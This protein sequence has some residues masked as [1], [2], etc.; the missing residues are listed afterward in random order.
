[1][2]SCVKKTRPQTQTRDYVLFYLNGLRTE[3]RGAKVLMP[4]AEWLRY[5]RGLTGT[6]IVC[7]EGDCGACTLL[8]T[9]PFRKPKLEA[10]NS[11]IA[12]VAHMDGSHVVT[13]EG[14]KD[15]DTL[16]RAQSAMMK[17]HGSQCG[18]C[19]PGF[20]MAI[21]WMLE[22]G[23]KVDGRTAKNHLTGNLCRCTGYQ[24]IIDAAIEAGRIPR[25]DTLLD[26]YFTPAAERE[27]RDALKRPVAIQD[28]LKSFYAPT[29]LAELGKLRKKQ[30]H[31]RVIAGA[32]DLGVLY[33]KT[34][35][36]FQSVIS[37][38][39]IKEM[40][41]LKVRKDSTHAGSCV[42]LGEIRREIAGRAPSVAQAFDLFA[43]PQ[44]KNMATLVGNIANASPIADT[45]PVMLALDAILWVFSPG[46][47]SARRQPLSDFFLD[48]RKTRLKPGDV[49][50][51][52]EFRLPT[53]NESFKFYKNSQRKDLDISCV[54]AAIW[55]KR[56]ANGTVSDV[57]LAYGG[58]GPTVI[59]LKKTERFL[60]GRSAT[61]S[62][63]AEA[64]GLVQ[65]E[66]S[67]IS[68]LRGSAAYRR[69]LAGNVFRSIWN[70]IAP[71]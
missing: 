24:Q 16:D 20:V 36:E 7:A 28:E 65:S 38:H 4:F 46:A 54:N 60:K 5:E 14:L 35:I 19:T 1:M 21:A 52:V 10:V 27:L 11:C 67:P 18:F 48:Y 49:I 43:S 33:N 30:P 47:R 45:P 8:K 51:G 23:K 62:I 15:K 63:L 17:N 66:I 44:I 3:V 68:D 71:A 61:Q 22:K 53:R 50:V 58:V 25:A 2:M 6:K 56:S 12:L 31:S 39:L 32:T 37:L 69:V 13:I 29:T 9:S 57:R 70:E 59:R 42:S 26:R 34:K 40:H 64:E 41:A 55:L